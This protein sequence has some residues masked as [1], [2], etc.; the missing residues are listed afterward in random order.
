MPSSLWSPRRPSTRSRRCGRR[1]EDDP[2]VTAIEDCDHESAFEQFQYLF[3][4]DPEAVEQARHTV[5]PASF[6][7]EAT[8][9]DP[10]AL[11]SFVQHYQSLD[12]VR[13]AVLEVQQRNR[14]SGR[15]PC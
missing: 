14:R 13:E 3:A 10:A 1:W 11:E 15:R 9:E 12:G 7:I 8:N 4:D 6:R 5:L 2:Q